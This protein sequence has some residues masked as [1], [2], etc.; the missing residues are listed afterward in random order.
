MAERLKTAPALYFTQYQGLK[1]VELAELRKKLRPLNYK[2][3]VVKN[4]LVEYALKDAGIS[5]AAEETFKGPIGLVVGQGTDPVAAIKVLATFAKEFPKLKVRAGYMDGQWLDAA[6]CLKLSTI[7][8]KPEL[9]SML[10]GTLYSAVS[11][12]AS[13]LQAPIR[14]LALTLKALEEQKAKDG[15]APAAA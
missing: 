5:G 12:A 11:Q 1:F 10:V 8:T 4:S 6:A 13:V 15:A 9:L 3:S 2:Y 7:G 14:D